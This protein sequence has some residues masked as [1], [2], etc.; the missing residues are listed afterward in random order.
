MHPPDS[1]QHAPQHAAP[2]S[3]GFGLNLRSVVTVLLLVANGLG[4]TYTTAQAGQASD[5]AVDAT[6]E[7]REVRQ[8]VTEPAPETPQCA[9]RRPSG[10][11]AGE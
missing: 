7:I 4:L 6:R 1:A 10:A 3:G 2:S 8:E 9:P 11:G 5:H